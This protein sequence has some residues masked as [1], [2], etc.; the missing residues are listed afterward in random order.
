MTGTQIC[1]LYLHYQ[2][3]TEPL[4]RLS[5]DGIRQSREGGFSEP[6]SILLSV[7]LNAVQFQLWNSDN[8]V[9]NADLRHLPRARV[10]A[11]QGAVRKSSENH[12]ASV[13]HG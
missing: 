12:K 3:L 1:R 11:R 6:L 7:G 5:Y 10:L 4:G 2:E 13:S 9:L 8:G